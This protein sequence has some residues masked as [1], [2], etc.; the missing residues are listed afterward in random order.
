ML[1]LFVSCSSMFLN[2]LIK[3]SASFS[4]DLQD[5]YVAGLKG[6]IQQLRSDNAQL[7]A[8]LRQLSDGEQPEAILDS[9]PDELVEESLR[10][11]GLPLRE[12]L[13]APGEFEALYTCCT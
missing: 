2:L 7:A 1:A 13:P 11:A 9:L 6:L 10:L 12:V 8:A 5:Q 3:V 4:I